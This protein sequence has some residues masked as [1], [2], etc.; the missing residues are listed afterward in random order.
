MLSMKMLSLL[1]ALNHLCIF[2]VTT[3]A[4]KECECVCL[5][6]P[7]PHTFSECQSFIYQL[8]D[9]RRDCAYV[10]S[11]RCSGRGRACVRVCVYLVAIRFAY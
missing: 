2:L 4:H 6:V 7:T 3:D 10:I 11:L 5:L 1:V 9:R 8:N